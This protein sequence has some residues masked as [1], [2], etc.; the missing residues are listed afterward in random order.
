MPDFINFRINHDLLREVMR[1]KDEKSGYIPDVNKLPRVL[2][3]RKYNA[4]RFPISHDEWRKHLANVS[5]IR[6][7]GNLKLDL[8]FDYSREK[9]Q[10]ERK[11]LTQLHKKRLKDMSY[12]PSPKV[13]IEVQEEVLESCA[14]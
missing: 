5:K 9:P 8:Q 2:S 3:A 10:P 7:L 12:K 14:A 4:N 11:P 6:N 13:K 1:I